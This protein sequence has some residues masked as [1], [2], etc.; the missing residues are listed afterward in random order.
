MGDNKNFLESL[1]RSLQANDVIERR[2]CR[3]TGKVRFNTKSEARLF[4]QWMKWKYKKW[5]KTPERR[6][7]S[8]TKGGGK[9][10]QRY[11]YTCE[12]CGGY[13][14][15]KESPHRYHKMKEKYQKKYFG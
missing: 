4:I 13:H 14:V 3:A 2:K 6:K 1:F 8:H 9:P 15:T 11:E 12:H 10:E 7:R 5:L